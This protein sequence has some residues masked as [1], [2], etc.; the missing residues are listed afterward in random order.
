M[1][2]GTFRRQA[3]RPEIPKRATTLYASDRDVF[4]FLVDKRNPVAVHVGSE[5]RRLFRGFMVW[6][7]NVGHHRFGMLTFL[8]DYVCDNRMVHGAREMKA[9]AIRHTKFASEQGYS[10]SCYLAQ[11]PHGLPRRSA[12]G[13]PLSRCRLPG[14]PGKR[15]KKA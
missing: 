1:T 5:V 10:L 9:L 6:N 8:Y 2:A 3:T 13:F 7:S 11:T 14:G 12:D 4:I 15:R